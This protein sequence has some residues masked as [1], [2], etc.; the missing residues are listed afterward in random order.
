EVYKTGRADIAT[1][2]IGATVNIVTAKPLQ[3]PGMHGSLGLKAVS[4]ST[5]LSGDDVTPELSGI[6]SWTDDSETF[7]VA[8]S[9]SYQERDSGAAGA[10]LNDWNIGVWGEDNLYSLAQG[11]TI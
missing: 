6:F 10:A 8:V 3:K 5:N 9:A 1:G 2:G 4:D 7:G 11:A